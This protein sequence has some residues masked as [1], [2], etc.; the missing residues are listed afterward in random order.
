MHPAKE[1]LEAIQNEADFENVEVEKAIVNALEKLDGDLKYVQYELSSDVEEA[2]VAMNKAIAK[3]N[4]DI[5][6]EDDEDEDEEELLILDD[7]DDE[8]EEELIILEEPEEE[9]NDEPTGA[10]KQ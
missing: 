2:I 3:A 8:G 7:E 6:E 5:E 1:I 4:S 9:S 10:E